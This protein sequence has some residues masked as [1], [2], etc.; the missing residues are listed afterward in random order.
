[1]TKARVRYVFGSRTGRWHKIHPDDM[2]WEKGYTK[3]QLKKKIAAMQ[4]VLK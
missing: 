4:K 3:T 1:M 2:D